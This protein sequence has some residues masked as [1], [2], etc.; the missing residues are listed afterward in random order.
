M[1]DLEAEVGLTRARQRGA[2]DRIEQ[3]DLAFFNRCREAYRLRSERDPNRFIRIN[4]NAD[5]ETV[6][7]TMIS[8]LEARYDS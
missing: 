4:A 8:A 3:E 2:L 7:Q 5:I 1:V 6:T